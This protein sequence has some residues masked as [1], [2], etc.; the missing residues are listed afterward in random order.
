QECRG[1]NLFFSTNIAD[2]IRDCDII[3][4]SVNTPTKQFGIGKGMA[5]DLSAWYGLPRSIAAHAASS[6][7]VIEKSTV[8]VRTA[9]GL[10]RVLKANPLNSKV[11]FAI[12]SNPEFLAEGTAIRDLERPD[13][14]LIGGQEKT[15]L[16]QFA[17][18]VLAD[19]YGRWVPHERILTTNVWSSELS[20]LVANSF[21]A[22]RVSSVN[23]VSMLCE[24][25]GADVR[26]VAKAV[27]ADS[28]IGRKFL[29][30]S[31][32]FGGSCLQKDVLSLAYLCDFYGLKEA[33]EYWLMV[34]NMNDLQKCRFAQRVIHELFNTVN[35]KKIA[36]FGFAFKKNTADIRETAALDVCS[37][38]MNDGAYLYVYD[39]QVDETSARQE[40]VDRQS[41]L[42]ENFDLSKQFFFETSPAAAVK[43]AHAIVVLTEWG[44]IPILRLQRFF[45]CM[46][47]PAFIFDGR[48]ILNHRRLAEIG[49][50]VHG[51]VR[52]LILWMSHK[53]FLSDDGQRSSTDLPCLCSSVRGS[54][55]YSEDINCTEIGSDCT[56]CLAH[57]NICKFCV[58]EADGGMTN[59]TIQ[60]RDCAVKYHSHQ[61]IIKL[62]TSTH[63]KTAHI[64]SSLKT[65]HSSSSS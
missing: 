9:E 55:V 36:I 57:V 4:I 27:G 65:V 48:N 1:R 30:A 61:L 17:I 63:H 25:T 43:D 56:L 12:L 35:K 38:L 42:N 11:K 39:P 60:F 13:R 37:A 28:R 52:N 26:Q 5:A 59:S 6:K 22:Q 19:I 47:K 7:I 58:Q 49:F 29:D 2:S 31:V 40:L 16:G 44:R 8:P 23:A 51:T 45:D 50:E 53:I 62:L 54:F 20:K 15:P 64:N 46:V 18:S 33:S 10:H 32:G 3:F 21:L 34:K 24:R 14:V 41:R